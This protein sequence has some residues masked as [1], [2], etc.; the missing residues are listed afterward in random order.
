[1]KVLLTTLNSKYVH[2]ALG[3]KYLYL[4]GRRACSALELKEFTINNSRDY[5]FTELMMG[6]YDAICFSCYI[7]NIGK[8]LELAA[9]L[10]KADPHLRILLGGPEVSYDAEGLM[11]KHREIDFILTGEGEKSFPMWCRDF[12]QGGAYSGIPGLFYRT[13]EWIRSSAPAEPLPMEQIPSPYETFP[14]EKDKV[15]YYESSRGCPFQCSYCIS[16]LDRS[17]RRLP[18]KRVKSDLDC[19]IQQQVRQVK[20]LDRT[21]NWDKKRSREIFR[22]LISCDQG[23]TNFHFEICADL[24]DEE[25]LQLLEKA[26]PGLFQFEIGIQSANEK[27]LQAVN[28]SSNIAHVLENVKKLADMGNSHI[29]TD[30][31]AGLPYEDYISFRRSFN[32]VYALG[33][34]NL[35][36]GFLK[37]LKGTGIREQAETYKYMFME[38]APYQVISNRFITAKELCRLKQIEEVLDLYHNRGGFSR[39]LEFAASHMAETPFDFYEKF[40]SYYYEQGFQHRSHKKEDL[41]RIFLSFGQAHESSDTLKRL[42]EAD[43]EQTMN[44]DAVKKFKKKGWDIR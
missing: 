28:R 41:Y 32:L 16:S 34:D 6:E 22:H 12:E 15:I 17:M 9:D 36:L 33:A 4:T 25:T 29:H 13:G 38:Q 20:F 26:R 19:F 14:C 1:M 44:F 27:T 37:L 7:W 31:I 3:L 39:S 35:Q 42:L 11:K 24:L 21:F 18:L 40:A 5:I 23:K 30:L 8:I 10:K 43:L 2:S